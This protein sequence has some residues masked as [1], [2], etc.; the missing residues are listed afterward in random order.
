MILDG[1]PF[2]SGHFYVPF[3]SQQII[4]FQNIFSLFMTF[5]RSISVGT[6]IRP[7]FSECWAGT[8]LL[9]W[10]AASLSLFLHTI[11]VQKWCPRPA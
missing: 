6:P 3:G 2:W 1:M 11:F 7:D 5:R 4:A 9:G 8:L 10:S